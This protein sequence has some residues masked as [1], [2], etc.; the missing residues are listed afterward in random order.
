MDFETKVKAQ[1]I[2]NNQFTVFNIINTTRHS[3]QS[4]I[5]KCPSSRDYF[6]CAVYAFRKSKQR[7]QNQLQNK[8]YRKTEFQLIS[9][10]RG[11]R[12]VRFSSTWS[13]SRFHWHPYVCQSSEKGKIFSGKSI[14]YSKNPL[15]NICQII[16]LP[17]TIFLF[18]SFSDYQKFACNLN[19]LHRFN[20]QKILISSGNWEAIQ[21]IKNTKYN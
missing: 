3:A 17:M 6:G 2:R 8:K 21:A 19:I 5:L 15:K 11:P 9:K 1:K 12:P 10:R 14:L 4:K 16:I 18:I 7:H 20:F 13:R